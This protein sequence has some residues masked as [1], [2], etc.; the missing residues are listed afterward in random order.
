[1]PTRF[2]VERAL[3]N[4]GLPHSARD[5]GFA[6]CR[7]MS[8]G[9]TEIPAEFSPSLTT[10]ARVVGVHRRTI[11]RHLHILETGG[12]IIRNRPSQHEARTGHKTTHYTVTIPDAPIAAAPAADDAEEI[13]VV[14][15][16]L[17]KRTKKVVSAEWAAKIRAQILDRPGIRNPAAFLR[18]V[19]RSEK[20][21]ER[22]LPTS[23]PPPIAEL[24]EQLRRQKE[25]S[26]D[27]DN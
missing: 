19:I 6:L 21:P 16:E 25:K 1:M 22:W 17:E 8:Q 7:R 9:S 5:I 12:W 13:A 3:E 10:L 26:D 14:V 20:E 15:D 27:D 11:M 4:S 23:Q 24:R 18:K 2:D